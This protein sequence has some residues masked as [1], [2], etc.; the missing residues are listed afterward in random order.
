MADLTKTV[1][2]LA[3]LHEQGLIDDEQLGDLVIRHVR[4]TS[5]AKPDPLAFKRHRSPK[6]EKFTYNGVR[7]P[8]GAP[9]LCLLF[10]A[11]HA[12]TAFTAAQIR[13][14]LKLPADKATR[15]T[16]GSTMTVLKAK[17]LVHHDTPSWWITDLGMEVAAEYQ[18]TH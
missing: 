12:G 2:A 6:R 16:I 10:L 3:L 9:T 4:G 15:S 13:R 7:L 11:E 18:R 5:P 17:G 14:G 8:S 1:E